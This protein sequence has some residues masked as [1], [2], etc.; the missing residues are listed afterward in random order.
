MQKSYKSMTKCNQ[1]EEIRSFLFDGY[2]QSCSEFDKAKFLDNWHPSLFI[3]YSF[4][5]RRMKSLYRTFAGDLVMAMVMSEIWQYNLGRYFDRSG[6]EGATKIL[7]NPVARQAVLPPCN[8]Y[9]ISQVLGVP[10]ETVR[11]KVFKLVELGWVKRGNDGEL[12][13]TEMCEAHFSPEYTIEFMHEFI[14]TARHIVG[15]L[16]EEN[17]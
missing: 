1:P 13:S 8:A 7:N 10:S 11:R 14:S 12:I 9:S 5:G 3:A 15:M 4:L 2:C 16:G 6:A 17:E